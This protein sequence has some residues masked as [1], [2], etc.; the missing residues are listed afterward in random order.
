MVRTSD[1]WLTDHGGAPRSADAEATYAAA[2]ASG[3][4]AHGGHDGVLF[5]DDQSIYALLAQ[6]SVGRTATLL[7]GTIAQPESAASGQA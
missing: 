1:P 6:V 3:W 7:V 4:P 2:R 5:L